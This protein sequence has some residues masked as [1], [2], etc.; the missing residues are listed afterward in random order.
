MILNN[1]TVLQILRQ[2]DRECHVQPSPRAG[3]IRIADTNNDVIRAIENMG[4]MEKAC[5][6]LG[7][8]PEEADKWIDEY[9]VPEPFAATINRHTRYSFTSIQE[10]TFYVRDGDNYWPHAPSEHE[11]T[12]PQGMGLYMEKVTPYRKM[13]WLERRFSR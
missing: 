2:H 6:L 5:R 1:E 4:G 7:V 9:Y 3:H 8:T 12:R 13:D 11:L 10:P